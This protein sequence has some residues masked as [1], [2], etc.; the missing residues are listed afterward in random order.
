MLELVNRAR[1]NPSADS[2]EFGISLNQGPS[3]GTIS[4]APKQVLAMNDFLNIS[5]D[6]HSNWMLLTAS[7]TMWSRQA[8]RAA[9][10]D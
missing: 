2:R 7:S 1:M 3:A 8:F 5:A 9:A 6:H 4:T 10:P